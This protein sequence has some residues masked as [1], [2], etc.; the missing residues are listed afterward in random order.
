MISLWVADFVTATTHNLAPRKI[1]YAVT[2]RAPLQL[3]LRG[4]WL[5]GG[6]CSTSSAI[7]PHRYS[8]VNL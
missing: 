8:S 7:R 1:D 3:W 5:R 6:S 4:W 2:H